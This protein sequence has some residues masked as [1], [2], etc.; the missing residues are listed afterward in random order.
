L[1]N[2]HTRRVAAYL[3][4]ALYHYYVCLAASKDQQIKLN[5]KEVEETTGK[6][7]RS[8]TLKRVRIRLEGN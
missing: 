3:N 8:A 5:G 2:S 1:F 4:K 7:L 6:L